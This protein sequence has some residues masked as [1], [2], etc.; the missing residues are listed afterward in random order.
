MKTKG[1]VRSTSVLFAAMAFAPFAS[2]SISGTLTLV[3][4][5]WV[6]P[7]SVPTGYITAWEPLSSSFNI[8][9]TTSRV[10]LD[11]TAWLW[12][13]WTPFTSDPVNARVRIIVNG[14]VY[15]TSYFGVVLPKPFMPNAI[16]SKF[17]PESALN[18]GS[19]TVRWELDYVGSAIAVGYTS[20]FRY[21]ATVYRS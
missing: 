1:L 12:R 16:Y 13:N 4:S 11:F 18:M 8:N 5:P 21:E 7:D 15:D 3:E 9:S 10:E 14:S 2:A 19:N 20:G 6:I 17:V